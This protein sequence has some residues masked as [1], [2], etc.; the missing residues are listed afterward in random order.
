MLVKP[1]SWDFRCTNGVNSN[2]SNNSV[3]NEFPLCLIE[4]LINEEFTVQSF[5][6]E[7]GKK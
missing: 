4:C 3:N 5:K 6:D 7:F 1:E 2:S